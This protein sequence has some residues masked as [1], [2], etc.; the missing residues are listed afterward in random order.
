MQKQIL[1]ALAL[2]LTLNACRET[3]SEPDFVYT[4][5][6]EFAADLFEQRSAADGSATLGLWVES[7][8]VYDGSNYGIDIESAVSGQNLNVRI[9]GIKAPDTAA[10]KPA[11][12]TAFAPFGAL[13]NGVYYLKVVLGQTIE[14]RLTLNVENGRYQFTNYEAQGVNFRNLSLSQLPDGM[15]WGYADAGTEVKKARA[16]Q[17][18]L[19]L[20]TISADFN[21]P[22]GYY[23]YFTVTGTGTVFLHGSLDPGDAHIPFV[24]RL[25]VS[26][27]DMRG[28]LQSYRDDQQQPLKVKCLSTW[29]EL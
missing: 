21:L 26:P 4:G 7:T 10:G 14:S 5:E 12:A 28:L 22:A 9:K 3:Y 24:R 19:D 18:A 16:E 1:Y 23:G 29:G 20:K 6:I 17:F 27:D 13:A 15:I 25:N 11:R 2:L 8:A